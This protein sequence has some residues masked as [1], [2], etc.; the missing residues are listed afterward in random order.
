MGITTVSCLHSNI[1]YIH[2]RAHTLD[3]FH[4][5]P[6]KKR[7]LLVI[8]LLC[9]F[10]FFIASLWATSW[11]LWTLFNCLLLASCF[12]VLDVFLW[13][14]GRLFWFV[15][16]IWLSQQT[17]A[18]IRKHRY[19][20]VCVCMCGTFSCCLQTFN[21]VSALDT[22]HST[23][24]NRFQAFQ[25]IE[26]LSSTNSWEFCWVD[27]EANLLGRIPKAEI[28]VHSFWKFMIVKRKTKGN[29]IIKLLNYYKI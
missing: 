28:C 2:T 16:K 13:L 17:D 22:W 24:L 9:F 19:S 14:F 27:D 23:Q 10:L 7:N 26:P 6:K 11:V 20:I 5:G 21:G 15:V 12:Y 18:D 25:A 3:Y 8:Y 4:V 29:L 1:I